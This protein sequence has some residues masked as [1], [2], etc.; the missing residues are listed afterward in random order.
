MIC[1]ET[2]TKMTHQNIDPVKL[3][4]SLIQCPSVTPNQ[5][6]ALDLIQKI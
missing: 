1:L 2:I 6:G 4:Q 5:A 3:S